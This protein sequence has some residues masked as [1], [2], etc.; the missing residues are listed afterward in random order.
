MSKLFFV[1]TPCQY[2]LLD[3]QFLEWRNWSQHQNKKA[4]IYKLLTSLDVW[5]WWLKLCQIE[6]YK[7]LIEISH[8]LTNYFWGLRLVRAPAKSQ[9]LC[10]IYLIRYTHD[11]YCESGLSYEDSKINNTIWWNVCENICLYYCLIRYIHGFYCKSSL[12]YGEVKNGKIYHN[13]WW[14]Y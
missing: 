13:L 10:Y 12:Q 7:V 3:L 9:I 8:E 6:V 4:R 2:N 1:I 11:F 14:K 5:N